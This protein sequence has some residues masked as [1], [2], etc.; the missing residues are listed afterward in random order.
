MPPGASPLL[1]RRRMR[2]PAAWRLDR[3][4]PGRAPALDVDLEPVRKRVE[5]AWRQAETLAGEGSI[6][7]ARALLERAHRR[8]PAD[9]NL[10]LDLALIRLR[11]GDATGS[12]DL[13][14]AVARRHDVREAWA[15]LAAARL[16]SGD[17]VGASRACARCLQTHVADEPLVALAQ[18]ILR[19]AQAVAPGWCS[20]DQAGCL[21]SN[22]SLG[23]LS[24]TLDGER[25]LAGSDLPPAWTAA[26]ELV[27]EAH[28]RP[29]LGSPID[30]QAI[31]R[32]EGFAERMRTGIAGWAWHPASPA[33][34]PVLRV[35]DANGAERMS[36]TATDLGARVDGDAPGARPRKFAFEVPWRGA[37][38]IVG[39]DGR[40]LAGSPVAE[41]P[42][43]HR[44]PIRLAART[45][46]D[47]CASVDVVIPIFRGRDTTLACLT[48]VM[49]TASPGTRIWV[50]DDGSPDPGLVA[51]MVA[52]AAAGRIRLIGSGGPAAGRVN[53]GFPAAANAGLRAAA[54]RDAVLLNSDTLVAGAWLQTL[55]AAAYSAP[56][57]GTATPISNEASI[58]STPNPEGGNPAP[59]LAGTKR[60]AAL[61]AQANAAR[62]VDIP[63]AHGFC[64][65]IRADCLVQTGLLRE[66]LFAQGYGEENDFCSRASALG[67]RHVAVPSVYVAH[68]GG[69]S[70]GASRK[71]LL[72][73]NQA[74]LG[75]LHPGYHA[76]V[77]SHIAAD[78]LFWARRRLDAAR[79]LDSAR[80]GTR[81]AAG[82]VLLVTHDH[83]GGTARVVADRVAALRGAGFDPLVLAGRGGLTVLQDPASSDPTPNLRFK[84]PRE[85]PAL[86]ALL[87][88][89]RPAA[90]EF[91]HLLGHHPA[92]RDLPARLGIPVDI[93]VH[94]Y[95]CLC[96]R[97][98]L[99]D[100]EAHYCGEP[101]PAGC[102]TC[103]ATS[104][105]NDGET[106]AP[107]AL[108]MRSAAAFA[109]ARAVIVPSADVADRLSR[110]FPGLS[111]RIAP[112]ED[113]RCS[114]DGRAAPGPS[115]RVA[116]VGAIG[117]EKGYFVILACARD[118][119]AR[120]LNLFFTIV[121]YT[122][123]DDAL[124]ATGRV[125][126]S[127][128]FQAG[129]ALRLIREQAA[130]LAFIP[131]VWP[132][133]WCFALTEVWDAGLPVCVF[134]LGTQAARVRDSGVGWVI[135]LSLPPSR[136]NDMLLDFAAAAARPLPT[137]M[138]QGTIRQRPADPAQ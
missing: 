127:G 18:A 81:A 94:D 66:D 61:A 115:V 58:L 6:P 121:G 92:I 54:G 40:D 62:L 91:H 12:A 137:R 125:A 20:L 100:R 33:T 116:V 3:A 130:Q 128:P 90:V 17:A 107:A 47:V 70:F 67:W 133:T 31:R 10:L 120:G 114:H 29:L 73:R 124:E 13:F 38:R 79:W 45:T 77:A 44:A 106:I 86:L 7:E 132:E 102:A 96:A 26:A 30:V 105:R 119:A 64:M 89:W 71:H 108:R 51:D 15:G 88:P 32:V 83:G 4:P 74:L 25:L 111:L 93:W 65:F 21:R 103:I 49:E 113:A 14:D 87:A 134:D 129:E 2:A 75:R 34:D 110:H 131:S 27:V 42:R 109:A 46:P 63:T 78:P 118:A 122:I 99:T 37:V 11:D 35:L 95:A 84:L 104:G 23:E 101:P 53:R 39:H 41:L 55:Q 43:R 48:A 60:I 1:P 16:V 28:G 9:Q 72:A 126:I 19:S 8:A 52:L 5:T 50:V 136:V 85:W 59:D 97:I 56:D 112:W 138:T 117:R 123:D 24:L 68:L 36:F 69:A 76:A 57:I 22:L 82:A 98:T 80:P 135:P